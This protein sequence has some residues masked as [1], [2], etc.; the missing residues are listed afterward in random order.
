VHTHQALIK[1][2][3]HKDLS[4]AK[5]ALHQDPSVSHLPAKGID[6]MFDEI[7]SKMKPYLDYYKGL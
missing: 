1:A 7:A 5:K 3:D 2:F 6:T 4:Y